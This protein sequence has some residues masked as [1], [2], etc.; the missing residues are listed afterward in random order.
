M[1]LAGNIFFVNASEH[2]QGIEES[3][4]SDGARLCGIRYP[5]RLHE[6]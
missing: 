1:P 6:T 5:L 4:P 3:R 2:A